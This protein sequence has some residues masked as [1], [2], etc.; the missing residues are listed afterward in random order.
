M[1]TVL[2]G[3]QVCDDVRVYGLLLRHLLYNN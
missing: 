3:R 2:V 1:G